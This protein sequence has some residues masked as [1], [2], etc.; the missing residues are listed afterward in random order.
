[1][2]FSVDK[3]PNIW[4]HVVHNYPWRIADQSTGD[5]A[6]DSYHRYKEDADLLQYIGVNQNYKHL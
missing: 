3:S 1:M 5:V 6:C 4:D 2:I